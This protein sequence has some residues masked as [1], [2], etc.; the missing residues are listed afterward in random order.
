MMQI[1]RIFIFFR[2]FFVPIQYKLK[3]KH[4]KLDRHESQ[5]IDM[6]LGH[7]CNVHTRIFFS[8][9]FRQSLE[10]FSAKS[11]F[12]I[13]E[14]ARWDHRYPSAA[15]SRCDSLIGIWFH[16]IKWNQ[17][18]EFQALE[19]SDDIYN[20]HWVSIFCPGFQLISHYICF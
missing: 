8:S 11:L 10:H 3:V 12:C 20:F 18:F 15:A 6:N 7:F 14:F 5:W 1:C 19:L 13:L 9:L 17:C 16:L 4:E 2:S